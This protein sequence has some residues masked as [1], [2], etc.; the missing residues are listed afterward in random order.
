M[1]NPN[2]WGPHGW[3]FTHYSALGQ[4]L[5]ILLFKIKTI[6]NSFITIFKIYYHVISAV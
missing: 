1:V 2:L 3:K 6:I 5:I 4:I